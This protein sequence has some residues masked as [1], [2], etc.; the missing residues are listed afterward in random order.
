MF[1]F[2]CLT[3]MA[4]KQVIKTVVEPA[5]TLVQIDV[6]NCFEVVL[7]TVD[8][9]EIQVVALIEGEYSK[10]LQ[11]QVYEDGKTLMIGAGF[12]ASFIN[13]NDKLSAHKVV[14]IALHIKVP[15]WK[16]VAVFGTNTRVI[17]SGAYSDLNIVLSDGLCELR[18]VSK[19][20]AVKTQSGNIMVATKGGKIN[21][22]SKYGEIV[23]DLIPIGEDRYSLST[24]TGNIDVRK[25]E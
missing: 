25:L 12:S 22:R 17:A 9:P 7:E 23:K 24:V 19:V 3:A 21:A 20:V 4:Q 10:E 15:R 16:N 14:S 11:L 13:P 2:V 6:R 18:Q 1:Y 8:E 5:I